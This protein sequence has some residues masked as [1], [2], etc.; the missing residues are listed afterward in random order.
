L[1]DR[2]I[3]PVR[4]PLI[5]AAAERLSATSFVLDGEGVILKAD[6]LSDFDRLRSPSYCAGRMMASGW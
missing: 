5:V 6:G 2:A 1:A 4:Y 3:L